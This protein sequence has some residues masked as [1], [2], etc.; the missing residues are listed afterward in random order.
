MIDKEEVKY[1]AHLSRLYLSDDELERF[2]RE[3]GRILEYVRKLNEVDTEGVEPISHVNEISNVM[4]ED[5]ARD[6]FERELMLM[7]APE[8]N[9]E[10]FVVPRVI[11]E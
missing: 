10:F 5:K 11:E 1:I 7:S 2:S 4:R 9:E 3:L 6:S 8:A